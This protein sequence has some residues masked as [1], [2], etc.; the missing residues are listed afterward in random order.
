MSSNN[1]N[2]NQ[3]SPSQKGIFLDRRAR[4]KIA[5]ATLAFLTI[6][7]VF[8]AMQPIFSPFSTNPKYSELGILGTN[9][10]V[11]SYPRNVL[12]N[13]AFT[14]Y[15]YLVNQEGSVR[16][17]N[18]LVK[19]GNQSTQISNSTS[20]SAPLIAQYYYSLD[21]NRTYIFPMDLS[22]SQTG[23]NQRLIFELWSYHRSSS[24]WAF[25]YTGVWDQ[26]WLNV[27]A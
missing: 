1:K 26:I 24:G 15:G 17:Y 5:L 16:Y 11:G 25:S 14:L 27:T 6:I 18:V 22:I 7:L 4:R 8:A 13:Q 20:S 19:L 21:N 2:S 12:Q 10:T 23:N 3:S 9:M